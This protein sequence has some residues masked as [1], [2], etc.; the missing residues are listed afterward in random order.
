MSTNGIFDITRNKA[1]LRAD[2]YLP[3]PADL[4][5]P[6]GLIREHDLRRGDLVA[7]QAQGGKLVGVESVNGH[8]PGYRRPVFTDLTPLYPNERLRLETEPHILITRV[9]D[10]V[11]PVGKGQRATS[12]SCSTR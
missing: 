5:V 11:M 2:G 8:R 4:T 12:S 6:S 1:L 7:G 3:S 10:L 9:S